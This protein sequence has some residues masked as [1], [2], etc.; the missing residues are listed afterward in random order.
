MNKFLRIFLFLFVCLASAAFAQPANDDP[1]NATPLSIAATCAY[2]THNNNNATNTGMPGPGCANY[3]GGDVWFTITVPASGAVTVDS[4]QGTMTDGGMAFYTG[5]N[6]SSLTLL[7]CDDDNSNNG[8]MP[9]LNASGLTP[10]STLYVRF[11]EYGNNGNGNFQ[12]CATS[13][14]DPTNQDCPNAIPICQNTYS[15]IVSYSGTGSIP[16]EINP[17]NSCLLSGERNDVWYT[18][19]VNTSGV[20]NFLITPVN[21]LDDYD[22][23]VYNLTSANCSD[24]YTNTAIRVSCNYSS[25]PGTTGPNG[26]GVTNYQNAAGVRY[27]LTIPVTAGQTYVVNVS[28]YTASNDGYSIDFGASTANIFDAVP[29]A[30]VSLNQPLACGATSVTFN[31]SENIQCSSV[32]NGDFTLTGPG[33]PYTLSNWTS[34]GCAIGADYD[35]AYTVT[36]SPPITTTGNYSFCLTNTSGSVMDLCGNIA[37]SACLAFAINAMTGNVNFTNVSCNGGTNGTITITANGGTAPIEYSIDNGATFQAGNVFNGLP[38]GNYNVQAKDAY[39]CTYLAVVNI[40]EPNPIVVNPVVV[41]AACGTSNGSITINVVGGTGALQYSNNNGA[42]FQASNTFNNL[43]AGNYDLVVKDANNCTG[44]VTVSVN[45]SA[46]PAINSVPSVDVSCNGG[47][48]GSIT[49]NANGGTGALQFSINNGGTFQAGN[50]FNNLPAGTYDI[51]VEDAAGCQAITSV[52]INEPPVIVVNP[53]SNNSTCG[54]SNGNIN[55]NANGGTGTLQYSID[56]GATFQAGSSFN[57]LPSG[58]Y[59]IVVEDANGCQVTA[60]IVVNDTPGPTITTTPATDASC[61]G[62]SDGTITINSNGGT[63]AIQYSIDNGVT[64]QPANNFISLPAGNYSIIIIDANGCQ[65]TANA[66]INEPPA[67]ALNTNPTDANCNG[68]ADGSVA[69]NANGGTGA[70][71]YSIDNGAT[72]QGGNTFNGL[73]AGN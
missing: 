35:N 6:C 3:S 47:N 29:P 62:G 19:T 27:N 49:I 55:I 12:L 30:L 46:S 67:I 50:T 16:N 71:Q 63:G 31:F 13:G 21:M 45:N 56:N 22:W 37:P 57:N 60:N 73:P 32:Q 72:W 20:L 41:D 59:N 23:A 25:T 61:N 38:A 70:I 68:S 40:A 14:P 4:K 39:G 10:G 28:N 66:V 48:N 64:F 65:A 11:W 44:T 7:D 42:S 33:G 5:P 2:T 8:L 54:N 26:G 15:T 53:N 43:P 1:C 69:V 58:N 34:T 18:F 9:L 51:V 52:T 36:I 17:S 24:I